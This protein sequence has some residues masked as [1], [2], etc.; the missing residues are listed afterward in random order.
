MR[1]TAWRSGRFANP[2]ITY[3]IRIGKEDREQ[4]F[5]LRWTSITAE[6]E[7]GSTT[8]LPLTRGFWRKCPEIR[9]PVFREW[10][11][12]Q[13]LIPWPDGSPPTFELEPVSG[14]HFRLSRLSSNP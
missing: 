11:T 5:Q 13:G 9:N 10:F 14:R 12:A 6:I 8:E 7:G 2:S 1:V 3:G 4:Y